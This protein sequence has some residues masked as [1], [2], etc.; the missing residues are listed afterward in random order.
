MIPVRQLPRFPS[1]VSDYYNR[2][3]KVSAFFN[4]N[5]RDDHALKNSIREVQ[6]RPYPRERLVE[7]LKRQNEDYDCSEQAQE[8]IH[9][10]KDTQTCVVVTGQQVGL[11]SG[12]LYTIY[13]AITAIKL[14]EDLSGKLDTRVVPVF[15]LASDDHDFRE[16]N[17]AY[18]INKNN[19]IEEITHGHPGLD[20]KVPVSEII[21]SPDISECIRRLADSQH[22]TDF[23]DDVLTL[24]LS[25]Y[26]PGRSV[27]DAFAYWLTAL[28]RPF[29][30]ILIDASQQKVK[31]LGHDLFYAELSDHSPS[32]RQVLQASSELQKA[33]YHVQVELRD[34]QTCNVFYVE[35]ERLSLK[36]ENDGFIIKGLNRRISRSDLLALVRDQPHVFSPNVILRP[37]FQDSILPTI[38]Y[39]AGPGEIA[40]FA[41]L[42]GVYRHFDVH[43]PIVYPRAMATLV[44]K[45]IRAVLEKQHLGVQ[46]TWR[47]IDEL[48]R[49]QVD[50]QMPRSL[51]QAIARVE[52]HI[53]E[54]FPIIEREMGEYYPDLKKTTEIIRA[55][56]HQHIADLN[57]KIEKAL[58]KEN[59]I[60]IQQL[61]KACANLFPDGRIQERVLNITPFL[62]KYNTEMI[63]ELYR[64]L[65]IHQ[66]GHQVIN[67]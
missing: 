49:E 32:T 34:D 4:G 38:A 30:L 48:I 22:D 57:K 55:R 33:G 26:K 46:D 12:P 59:E 14:A 67:L 35:E 40:Y 60:A 29:G 18:I 64:A 6:N 8:N 42:E 17:H 19:V 2:Y 47:G 53:D 31:E 24:L 7:I 39:V 27:S 44:E 16:I 61:R 51:N 62:I 10:L 43:M 13:K 1:L 66:F 41:Q 21:L 3:E 20:R 28:F 50:E 56:M 37:L 58:K 9:A 5:F 63:G 25:A 54:D 65:D 52:S 36:L 23:K 15:W 11:F 45:K